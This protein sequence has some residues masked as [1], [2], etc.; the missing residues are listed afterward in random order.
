MLAKRGFLKWCALL[1]FILCCLGCGKKSG[2]RERN[3]TE[4]RLYIIGKAYIQSCYRLERAPKDFEEI[5]PS[6]EKEIPEDLLVSP[7]D[8]EKF[9]ILWDND[10]TKIFP[11][12]KDPFTVGAYEKNG[13]NGIRYVLLFPLGIRKMDEEAFQNAT[14]PKGHKAPL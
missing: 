2:G 8:K 1:C 7:N 10:F 14:F 11:G 13:V 4:E 12:S 3:P 6:I 5:K 9:V